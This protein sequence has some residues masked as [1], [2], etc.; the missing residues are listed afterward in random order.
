M[1]LIAP[2]VSASV[3]LQ[4]Q[5]VPSL[6]RAYVAYCELDLTGDD[7]LLRLQTEAWVRTTELEVQLRFVWIRREYRNR[8]TTVQKVRP[9]INI[10]RKIRTKF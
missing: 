9:I 4:L 3:L 1:H 7:H 5:A 8:R 6:Q 2:L 10:M